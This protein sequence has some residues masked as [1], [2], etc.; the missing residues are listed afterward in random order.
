MNVSLLTVHASL[1]TIQGVKM[2]LLTRKFTVTDYQKMAEMGIFQPEERVELIEGEIIKMS[3][4]GFKHGVCI[5]SLTN[6]LAKKLGERALIS[7]QNTIQL[8]NN[9]QPQP[10][11]VLLKNDLEVYKTR[12]P[13]PADIFLII[14][15]A[16]T[17]IKSDRSV[18][19]PLYAR[20]NIPEVWLVDINEQTVEVYGNNQLNNYQTMAKFTGDETVTI[21][22]FPDVKIPVNQI[23]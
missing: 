2:Q 12:H 9:S 14:E 18:K 1:L 19:I 6:I 15:V 21:M 20:A 22:A 5:I 13:Q 4:I 8:D 10:D 11:V 17:T 16:D 7:V 23:I 3:P